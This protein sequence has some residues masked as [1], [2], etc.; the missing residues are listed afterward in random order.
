[1][2]QGRRSGGRAVMTQSPVVHMA[3]IVFW[4][5]ATLTVQS[6]ISKL[7]ARDKSWLWH[8][9][10]RFWWEWDLAGDPAWVGVSPVRVKS[11]GP[12]AVRGSHSLSHTTPPGRLP[13]TKCYMFCSSYSYHSAELDTYLPI[14]RIKICCWEKHICSVWGWRMDLIQQTVLTVAP[15]QS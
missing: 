15:F 11:P 10:M 5:C 13:R 6:L 4:Y 7:R 12:P 8:G 3:N 1:M 9:L 2:I 14:R